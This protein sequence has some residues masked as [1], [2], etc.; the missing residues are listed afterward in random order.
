MVCSTCTLGSQSGHTHLQWSK[1]Q[2]LRPRWGTL[3]MHPCMHIVKV[4]SF[5]HGVMFLHHCKVVL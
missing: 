2:T 3:E 4:V 5:A 1:G